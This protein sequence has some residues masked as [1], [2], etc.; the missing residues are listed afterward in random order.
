MD[1]QFVDELE[2]EIATAKK[3]DRYREAFED[4]TLREEVIDALVALRRSCGLTQAE[5]AERM[6]VKQ[7]TVSGFENEGSD[8]RVSTLQ[9]YA[10]A[11]AAELKMALHRPAVTAWAPRPS[12]YETKVQTGRRAESAPSSRNVEA[13]DSRRSDFA[14]AA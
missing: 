2:A 13:W 12:A 4:A 14:I 1:V 3:D 11:V 6:G 9:R 5:V 8:P 10:R 7:P